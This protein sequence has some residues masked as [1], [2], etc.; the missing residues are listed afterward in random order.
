LPH[1]LVQ[2][3]LTLYPVRRSIPSPSPSRARRAGRPAH[4]C[5]TQ[6]L[7]EIASIASPY[8]PITG[9]TSACSTDQARAAPRPDVNVGLWYG[10]ARVER[11]VLP[12]EACVPARGTHVR[13]RD[14]G[15][16]RWRLVLN[17]R[18]RGRRSRIG[19]RCNAGPA[20]RHAP[21]RVGQLGSSLPVPAAR[22]WV[23]ARL[24]SPLRISSSAGRPRSSMPDLQA[25][26]DQRSAGA[27]FAPGRHHE[28]HW[29]CG[30]RSAAL[31]RSHHSPAVS[32]SSPSLAG[33]LEPELIGARHQHRRRSSVLSS[34]FK[35]RARIVPPN[36]HIDTESRAFVGQKS[37]Y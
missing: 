9:S 8:S 3:A 6:R 28:Q 19:R 12:E 37:S 33:P 5:P 7:E 1:R 36:Y 16:R 32:A 14:T 2:G 35:S 11:L 21:I 18:G 26:F 4:C 17:R 13:R 10:P 27:A 30:D 29:R 22:R 24:P 15:R 20:M 34:G 23:R 31:V 25:T